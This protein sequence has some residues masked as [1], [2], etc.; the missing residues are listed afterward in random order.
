[1]RRLGEGGEDGEPTDLALLEITSNISLAIPPMEFATPLR[2][3]DK[4]FTVL[5][6]PGGDPQGRNVRGFLHAANAAGL[7]QMDG[8]GALNVEGGF[9][10][11]AVWSTDVGA[12]VGLVVTEIS[13]A[14]VEWCIPSRSLCV[15]YNELPVRFRVPP[16]DR[17]R[18]NDYERDDPNTQIYGTV[19]NNGQRK[20]TARIQKNGEDNY[21]VTAIYW[22][23]N[24]SPAPRGGYVTFI[25]F[26]DFESDHEDAY[27][28]GAVAG[29]VEI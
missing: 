8:G 2:H 13:E 1:V 18:I 6:C 7:V 22:C 17:P 25:T 14:R 24:G 20:L 4:S 28:L 27:E 10:G 3:G 29:V 23:L 21:V 5:G 15:F 19:S 11:V 26:P 9:S 12:F 16:S